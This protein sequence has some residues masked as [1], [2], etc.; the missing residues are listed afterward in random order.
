[1]NKLKKYMLL[2][3]LIFVTLSSAF[4][5]IVYADNANLVVAYNNVLD[6]ISVQDDPQVG[7]RVCEEASYQAFLDIINGVDIGG[8]V[9]IQAVIDDDTANQND[10]DNLTVNINNALAGLIYE[11]TYNSTLAD[12]YS[13]KARDLTPYTS[14]SQIIYND[15]LDIIK[16]FLDNPTAGEDAILALALNFDSIDSILVLRGDKTNI[17]DKQTQIEDIYLSDGSDY[18]PSTYQAFKDL[19]DSIDTTLL[20]DIGMTL[21]EAIS[22]IDTTDSQVDQIELRLDEVINSLVLLPDKQTLIDSYN[23]ALIIDETLYTSSSY[24][25]F[26]AGLVPI[27]TVINNVE[28]TMLEVNQAISDLS[29]LY[30]VLVIRGDITDLTVL[31]NDII[32]QNVAAYTP[33][34]VSL[35]QNELDRIHDIMLSDDTDQSEVDQAESDLGE[36]SSLLVLQADRSNLVILNN[37]LIKAYY[38]EKHEYTSSSYTLFKNFVDAFGSYMYVNSIINDDNVSQTIVD[39]VENDIEDALDL[40]VFLEDNT[41][42]LSAYQQLL[43]MDLSEYT[44]NSQTEFNLELDRLYG[45]ALSDDLDTTLYT[46]ILNGF[47]AVSDILV[48]LPDYT[49]LQTKYD[50]SSIYREEDYS[51]SSYAAFAQA[52]SNALSTLANLNASQN[53]VDIAKQLLLT[54]IANL[55]QKQDIIYMFEDS[56]LD[57]KP[58]ITL[59][60]ATILGYSIDDEEVLS[61]DGQGVVQGLKFGKTKVYIT[62]SNGATEILDIFVK[63]KLNTTVYVLTFSIPVL[64]LGFGFALTYLRKDSWSK[65]LLFIKN[66]FK[67]KTQK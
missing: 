43:L 21:D 56:L 62:L 67:K 18:I 63:A 7:D 2:I 12:Y 6:R 61:I 48:E 54:S 45:L 14:A 44:L 19:Y 13:A 31:Y 11:D 16:S 52:K 47:A 32:L 30:S 15:E 24:A 64:G 17:I 66:I 33:N 26:T 39:D 46:Q 41:Q 36:V 37:L 28:A 65:L 34:S 9:G 40:L 50:N 60:G 49:L 53:D 8:L 29:T 27:N 58:Y 59:G 10:V 4:S 38:E 23:A 22:N 42:L 51:I 5:Y 3:S 20:A 35:Y 25:S 57:L 55:N 1:M